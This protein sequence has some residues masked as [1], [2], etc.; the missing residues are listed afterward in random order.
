[1]VPAAV[2]WLSYGVSSSYVLADAIDKGKKAGE[3]TPSPEEGRSTRVTIAVV[4]TFVWQ[5]LA[6]VA[7]PGFTINRVCAAS[8]YMLGT[9][10]RW[11]LAV[12]KWTT[13]A[14]GLLAIPVIIHPIDRS[15][16]FLLDSSL[17]KLYPSVQKPS[18]S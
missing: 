2:V 4:D 15:V 7:I 10:T 18:S 6:S 16:D 11:P 5:A 9:A 12:R 17:R 8:L 1:M 3:Q 13:T 14:L